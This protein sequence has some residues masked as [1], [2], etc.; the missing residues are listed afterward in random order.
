MS[1]ELK[2]KI[3][4]HSSAGIK[5]ENED[6]IN[7]CTPGSATTETKGIVSVLADGVSSSEAAKQASNIAVKSFIE[8]YYST[9]DTW[10]TKKSCQQVVGAINSW[11]YKQSASYDNDRQGMVGWVTTFDA[12]ILKSTSIHIVHIGDSRVYRLRDGELKQLTTDHITWLNADR[13]Y[14]SRAL[15]ADT[16]LKIDFQTKEM[17]QGDYYLQTTDGVHEFLSDEEIITIILT[18]QSLEEKAKRLV[19]KAIANQSNDNLSAQLIQITQLPSATKQEVYDKLTELPFPPELEPGMKLDGFEILQEI[20]LSA[21][22]QIYLAKDLENQQQLVIKT[23]SVNYNDDAWY[24]DGFVREEWI[25]QRLKHPGL[26]KTY[27]TKRAKQFLYF[28]TEYIEGISLKRWIIQNPAPQLNQVITYAEQIASALRAM[29]RQDVI[30]QDLKPDNIMLNQEERIKI[31]D[32]GAV[33]AAGLAELATVLQRQH[34]E[35][36]LNYTAPEYMMG[37]KGT[38]QSDIFSLSVIIYE[39]LTGKLPFKE[40]KINQFQL[41]SYQHMHYISIKKHRTDLPD[42]ID[43]ALRKGCM[44]NPEKRYHLLSELIHDLKTPKDNTPYTDYEP[45]LVRNPVLV[46]QGISAFF[47]VLFLLAVYIR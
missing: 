32:F 26:M 5:A 10:G 12:I 46:W 20:N 38:K 25:G 15:G 16:M 28:A 14:L 33:R 41:K 6:A 7:Y 17:K 18:Q 19:E 44:P 27:P 37:H 34:P 21:R 3:C 23:P 29:H 11:L 9:P 47:F 13:S 45:L 36:T 30:H 39:L 43:A 31:I 24:L 8:D 2:A 1:T 35:G 42:W 22:S 4:G 40:K